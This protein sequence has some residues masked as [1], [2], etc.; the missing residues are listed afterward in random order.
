MRRSSGDHSV[1]PTVLEAEAGFDT[2]IQYETSAV[3]RQSDGSSLYCQRAGPTSSAFETCQFG[4][5][6]LEAL[7]VR[8]QETSR[9]SARLANSRNGLHRSRQ[10]GPGR[11]DGKGQSAGRRRHCRRAAWN[12]GRSRGDGCRREAGRPGGHRRSRLQGLPELQERQRTRR[13]ARRRRAGIAAA[14]EGHRLPPLT[15]AAGRG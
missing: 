7:N 15:G 10:G 3:F 11:P 8:S 12:R 13:G 2:S 5:A 4:R 6:N 14:A 9:R 1:R